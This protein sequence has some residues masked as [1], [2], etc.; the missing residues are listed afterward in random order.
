MGPRAAGHIYFSAA[1]PCTNTRVL[2]V[3]Y[4]RICEMV[5]LKGTI[6]RNIWTETASYGIKPIACV[7]KI[8]LSHAPSYQSYNN[9]QWAPSESYFH[10]QASW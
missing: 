7:S 6:R 4:V 1:F 9:V 3:P 10:T 2:H 8:C 5:N